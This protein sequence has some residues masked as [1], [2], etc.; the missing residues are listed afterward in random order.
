[1]GRILNVSTKLFLKVEIKRSSLVFLDKW[2]K[3]SPRYCGPF[4]ILVQKGVIAYQLALTLDININDVFQ[5]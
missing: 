5:V 1:M 2:K 3:L 4:E